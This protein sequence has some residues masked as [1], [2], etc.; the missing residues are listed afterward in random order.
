MNQTIPGLELLSKIYYNPQN[1]G[2]FGGV[3]KLY[4]FARRE[5]TD[6]NK[7]EVENWLK[8]QNVY[9]L[10]KPI[11]KRFKR[12]KIYVSYIDE[13]W[14]CDLVDM[15]QYSRQNNGYKF[16]LVIID[17]FS[18]Y[19][20]ALP[21]KTKTTLEV[22]KEFKN[23]FKTRKPT[24]IRSDRGLEFN[25]ITFRN[26]CKNNNILF[27]TSQDKDIKCAIVERVNRTIKS[28]LFRYFTMKGTRKYIDVLQN[29]VSAYNNSTHRSIGMAP[30]DVTTEVEQMVF[31][32]LYGAKN[33]LQLMHKN[34]NKKQ[35]FKIGDQVRQKYD[36]NLLEKSYYPL[37]TDMVYKID[38]IHHKLNT[39]QY[40]I[41]ID[42][43]K[44]KRRFYP[45]ELQKVYVNSDTLWQIEKILSRRT[46]DKQ[47]QVLI[48]WKGYPAKFNQWIPRD[49]I[50]KLL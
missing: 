17:S 21:L 35:K 44:F 2:S 25:N 13:Q 26:F 7:N 20:F 30:A 43:E 1:P 36:L 39:P 45:E 12:N 34:N 27:F 6:I 4:E 47:K 8:S 5:N 10:H 49:Q 16:I 15:K 38:E 11:R 28:K 3:N 19:L 33:L 9:T 18:K 40:S 31:R 14:E 29:F 23:I 32:K 37:W 46:V 24:K 41:N 50:S 22:I 48:K 42:E